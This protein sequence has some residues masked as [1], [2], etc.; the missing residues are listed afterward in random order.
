MLQSVLPAPDIVNEML[1]TKGDR[2]ERRAEQKACLYPESPS[3]TLAQ[4]PQL[5][6]TGGRQWAL[7]AGPR[8]EE[9]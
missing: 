7:H 5:A 4:L 6:S 2:E 1:R 8:A 3:V 9:S